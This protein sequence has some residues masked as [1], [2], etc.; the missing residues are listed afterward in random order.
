MA[1]TSQPDATQAESDLTATLAAADTSTAARIQNLSLI[2]QA[3]LAQ[4]TRSAAKAIAQYG[5][6]SAQAVAAQA[7]VTS[8]TRTIGR[9][10]LVH[11]QVTTPAPQVTATGWAL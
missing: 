9:I 3:R 4:L 1:T 2:H 11:Q 10:A 7:D 6:G 8:A 5:A